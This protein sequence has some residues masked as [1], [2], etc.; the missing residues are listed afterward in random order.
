MPSFGSRGNRRIRFELPGERRARRQR[1]RLLALSCLLAGAVAA[2]AVL[3]GP[4]LLDAVGAVDA[5]MG[6]GEAA[7]EVEAVLAPPDAAP[8]RHPAIDLVRSAT[9]GPD[10]R[11]RALLADGRVATLTIDP[12]LQRKMERLLRDYR[13]P[14]GAVVALEPRTGRILALA[15]HSSKGELEGA[16][17]SLRPIAPAA[18]VF[19]IV[20]AAALLEAGVPADREVCYH[21][22]LRRLKPAL[23]E[24]S[25]RDHR[26]VT[27]ADA[28]GK[29]AN[30]PFAR[31]AKN[32]LD[33]PRLRDMAERFLFD[34]PI[35]L[36]GVE[37]VPSPLEIPEE[38]F[39]F[40]TTAAGFHQGVRLTPLH[41][42]LLTA[43]VA[44]NGNMPHAH[45][46][47]AIDGVE[48]EPPAPRHVLDPAV[49]RELALMMERTVK[50]GTARTAFLERRRAVMDGIRV[51]G[52]TGSL[53][54]R[55]P[56]RDASW[57]VGYAPMEDPRIAV[58]AVVVNEE[59]WHVR[60]PYVAREALRSHLLGTTPYR[61]R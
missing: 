9:L 47:E 16:G 2:W 35:V 58:A 49:A 37:V 23:L 21:G 7:V 19:K 52:K 46:V 13:V 36:E 3:R 45:L 22:G 57:F 15:E 28:L 50:D 34:R 20:T 5:S 6:S 14:W 56:F 54:E 12:V 31:L 44:N 43:A 30:V 39:E 51:A 40:A 8:M 27:L 29:S 60:A 42:A 61:P 11:L 38:T 41:G 59:I 25:P 10:G 26:C 4:L 18:S 1:R 33:P 32:H 24:E 48:V 55:D 17:I 53:F